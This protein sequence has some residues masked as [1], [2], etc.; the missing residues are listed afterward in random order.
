MKVCFNERAVLKPP[1]LTSAVEI[2][3]FAQLP[4]ESIVREGYLNRFMV[5]MY[6]LGAKC[7]GAHLFH[8]EV[9]TKNQTQRTHDPHAFILGRV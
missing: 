1:S 8:S 5:L 2:F 9:Y 6:L 4:Y 3:A 7:A